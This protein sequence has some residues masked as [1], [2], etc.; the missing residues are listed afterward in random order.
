MKILAIDT[1]ANTASV[2]VIENTTLLALQTANAKNTHSEVLLPMIKSCLDSLKL[3]VENMDAFA[4]S[5]GPGSFTGVRIGAATIKGLAFGT[6]KPC[7]S[8]SS[9]EALAE[10][11]SGFNGIVCPAMNARRGQVYSAI[12]RMRDGV[13]TRLCEDACEMADRMAELLAVYEE[14][15]YFTG[16]GAELMKKATETNKNVRPTPELL[17]YQN[18]YSVGVCAY[19][20]WMAGEGESDLT[21]APVYLRKPQAERE[22]EERL[23]AE[24]QN[25]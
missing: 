25:N 13:C 7:I 12:F 10:N 17:T 23:A 18:G 3:T 9:L 5:S 24:A 6:G 8:V 21:L 11:M 19:R 14:P 16:D 15:I 22:R 4:C 20:K 1:T 2:A